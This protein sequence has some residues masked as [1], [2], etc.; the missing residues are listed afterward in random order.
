MK[1]L[2]F[3]FLGVNSFLSFG[4]ENDSSRLHQ[5]DLYVGMGLGTKSHLGNTGLTANFFLLK[6]LN[7]KLSGGIGAFNYNGPLFSIGPEFCVGTSK[8]TFIYVG[9]VWTKAAK[10]QD[11]LGDDDSPDHVWY[12]T[13][14]NE[15]IRSYVGIG[16]GKE[17]LT[18]IEIGY[19]Y[20]L[21]APAY[22]FG[23]PGTAT[24]EYMNDI[25][26]GLGSGLLVSVTFGGIFN[27][28]SKKE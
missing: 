22:S 27:L 2:I 15:Y 17:A 5:F 11:I 18:K 19:S 8:S 26:R 14:K 9:S 24:T 16:I 12:F 10:R 6:N 1:K 7:I 28:K 25:E 13:E 21:K 4:H 3:F 23:G 20:A